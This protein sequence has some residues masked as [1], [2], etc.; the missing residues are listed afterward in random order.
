[1]RSTESLSRTEG[2]ASVSKVVN[3]TKGQ[4]VLLF[5]K[6]DSWFKA[7]ILKTI[8]ISTYQKRKLRHKNK[9]IVIVFLRSAGLVC[10][11]TV[12]LCLSTIGTLIQCIC[13]VSLTMSL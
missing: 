13:F 7:H 5:G 11:S 2:L 9:A 3:L 8:L 10:S 1:M 6:E 12:I 4:S